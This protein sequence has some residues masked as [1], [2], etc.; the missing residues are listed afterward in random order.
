MGSES[1]REIV[2]HLAA[3]PADLAGALATAARLR[4]ARPR[5]SV[6]LVINGPALEELVGPDPLGLV[7]G[8]HV[9]ACETG[10]AGRD[11]AI[12]DL[13]PGTTTIPMAVVALADAQQRGAAYIR[14]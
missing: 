1:V 13:R 3:P 9:E 11:I 2:L 8:I 14:L 7:E 12:S 4:A 6:T 10:L 5:T